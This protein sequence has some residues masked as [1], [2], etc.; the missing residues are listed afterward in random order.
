MATY[1]TFHLQSTTFDLPVEV[2]LNMEDSY[3]RISSPVH[4]VIQVRPQ[5]FHHQHLAVLNPYGL[6]VFHVQVANADSTR[7]IIHQPHKQPLTVY[8][9]TM[10]P[11]TG[12]ISANHGARASLLQFQVI[13]PLSFNAAELQ[14]LAAAIA[15][16]Y[17]K[18]VSLG[19]A[20]QV[21]FA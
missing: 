20:Q 4:E 8:F 3:V 9:D 10:Q 14:M 18:S 7:L 17:F 13:E 15:T 16:C 2:K 11:L 12:H 19:V 6:P 21:A 1:K 5:L